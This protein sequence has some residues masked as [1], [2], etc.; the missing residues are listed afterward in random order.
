M[1][2]TSPNSCTSV[3]LGIHS[4]RIVSKADAG[5]KAEPTSCTLGGGRA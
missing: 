5:L 4:Q 3:A 1:I 2:Y